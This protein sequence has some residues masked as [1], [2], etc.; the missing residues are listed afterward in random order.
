MRDRRQNCERSAL[1]HLWAEGMVELFRFIDEHGHPYVPRE[2]QAVS[3]FKL[4]MWVHLIRGYEFADRLTADQVADIHGLSGW[5][6]WREMDT[7]SVF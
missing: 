6:L 4:G 1:S 5:T 3:L 7:L 2:Y